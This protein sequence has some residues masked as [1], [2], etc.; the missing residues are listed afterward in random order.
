MPYGDINWGEHRLGYNGMLLDDNKPLSKV[1]FT[2]YKVQRYSYEGY[3]TRD[4]SAINHY[5]TLE[6]Y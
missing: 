5:N 4:N 1:D 3:I 6:N 2:I